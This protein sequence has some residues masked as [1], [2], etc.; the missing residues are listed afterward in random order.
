[1]STPPA[2]PPP[3]APPTRA[4]VSSRW[5]GQHPL[6]AVRV[7]RCQRAAPKAPSGLSRAVHICRGLTNPNK[8]LEGIAAQPE[9]TAGLA[10]A[11]GTVLLHTAGLAACAPHFGHALRPW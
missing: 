6:S 2:H 5:T 11:A 7:C 9:A 8:P 3:T 4:A 10:G 1:M